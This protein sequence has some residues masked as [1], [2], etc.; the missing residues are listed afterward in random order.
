MKNNKNSKK[1]K[2]K[3]NDKKPETKKKCLFHKS[4]PQNCQYTISS[5]NSKLQFPRLTLK[6]NFEKVRIAFGMIQMHFFLAAL[7]HK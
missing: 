4:H 7:E 3:A 5:K 6:L 1:K 2:K